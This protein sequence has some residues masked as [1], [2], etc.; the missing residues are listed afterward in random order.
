MHKSPANNLC[1]S[2]YNLVTSAW[3]CPRVILASPRTWVQKLSYALVTRGL[4][5]SVC[6]GLGV[7]SDLLFPAYA[8]F[9]QGLVLKKLF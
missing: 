8:P 5:K 4:Y 7:F 3:F 1:T 6:A 9:T 2:V